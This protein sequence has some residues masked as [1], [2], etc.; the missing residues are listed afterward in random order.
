MG[1][2]WVAKTLYREAKQIGPVVLHT[3]VSQ[4]RLPDGEALLRASDTPPSKEQLELLRVAQYSPDTPDEQ[5]L[6]A[7]TESNDR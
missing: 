1:A 6:R 2:R 4:K 3:K 7:S 5:L